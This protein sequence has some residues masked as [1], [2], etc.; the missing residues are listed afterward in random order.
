MDAIQEE[1]AEPLPEVDVTNAT[2]NI[3]GRL[4][5]KPRYVRAQITSVPRG[6]SF[7]RV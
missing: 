7:I 4:E 1:D 3:M 2:L 5:Y 6:V